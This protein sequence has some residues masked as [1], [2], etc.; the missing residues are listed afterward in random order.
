MKKGAAT[1]KPSTSQMA[2]AST[3][4]ETQSSKDKA[5]KRY[6]IMMTTL[7]EAS[8][9]EEQRVNSAKQQSEFLKHLETKYEKNSKIEQ[10]EITLELKKNA[11]KAP[12]ELLQEVIYQILPSN[13][14]LKLSDLKFL[15]IKFLV[16]VMDKNW[17]DALKLCGFILIYEPNNATAKEYLPLL[18]KRVSQIESQGESSTSGSS[19]S[20]DDQSDESESTTDDSD[21]DSSSDDDSDDRKTESLKTEQDDDNDVEIPCKI[22]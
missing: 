8:L 3:D 19:S 17:K 10:N 6:Q 21:Q 18:E 9:K 4:S 16:Y 11:T 12:N 14:T 1:P 5:E 20:S 2:C 13:I 22:R 15:F 7:K